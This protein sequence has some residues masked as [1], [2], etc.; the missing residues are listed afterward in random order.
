MNFG[1]SFV[2]T[3]IMMNLRNNFKHTVRASYLGYISQAIVN[4][5]A[6]L[7]FLI[8]KDEFGLDLGQI[9][10]ITTINFGIQLLV[11]A[12]S[13]GVI[14]KIGY[15]KSIVAAHFFCALGI[16]SMAVLPGLVGNAYIGLL[17]SV[18][19]YAVGGGIIEVLISPIVE[20]CPSE[21][22]AKAMSLLHSFYCW[23]T[24]AV[25]FLSTMFLWCFGKSNWRFLT[26]FWALI[27]LFN[28]IYFCFV[29]INKLVED[30]EGMSVGKLFGNKLFWLFMVLMV[31]AGA[32]EQA[33]SQ[34]ASSFAEG[35]LKVTKMVGDIA[36]PCFF[37]IL[38][39]LSRTFYGKKGEKIDLARFIRISGVLCVFSYLLAV[40]SP[41]P[42]LSL[43]GCGLCGLSVGIFWPGVFSLA[44]AKLPKGGTIMFALLALAGDVGCSGGPTTVGF[45]AKAL[46][47]NLRLGLLGGIVFPVVLIICISLLNGKKKK[48][49]T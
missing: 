18:F 29:P 16:V 12:V 34:W 5:L 49:L 7:L 24:V 25:V 21:N 33:M 42:L 32:S 6:P 38:M 2:D 1:I 35:G 27:P 41:V 43:L 20:A 44:S 30:N 37:S 47:E 4:N 19:F 3:G 23:G 31:T 36:G 13:A 15:R 39:G 26:F 10:L 14:D 22:K 45:L 9:T 8:F 48:Q 40:F 11:D 17:I 28:M 46:G